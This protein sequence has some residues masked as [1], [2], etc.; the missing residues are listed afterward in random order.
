MR[1]RSLRSIVRTWL[2]RWSL[3]AA[4]ASSRAAASSRERSTRSADSRFCSWLFSFCELTTMP[5]GRW[6]IRTA[7]SVVFTLCPPGPDDR[8]TSIRRSF[9]STLTSTSSA[10]GSTRTPAAD[11]W[12]RPWLSVT[13][14][15]CTRCTPPSNFS[16][17][18]MPSSVRDLTAT[19]TSL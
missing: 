13:G 9:G 2:R 7:E 15:R 8:K 6:V 10:S 12:M 18:Q 1:T 19:A 16:R 11:V 5:L 17:D 3:A 14:T 4:S